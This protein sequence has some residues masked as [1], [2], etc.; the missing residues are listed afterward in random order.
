[1]KPEKS[2]NRHGGVQEAQLERAGMELGPP[3]SADING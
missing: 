1:M 3:D 2:R